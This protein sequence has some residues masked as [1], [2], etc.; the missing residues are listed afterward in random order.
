MSIYGWIFDLY[1]LTMSHQTEI[2]NTGRRDF[3]T[4]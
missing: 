4:T 1:N 3:L 2:K